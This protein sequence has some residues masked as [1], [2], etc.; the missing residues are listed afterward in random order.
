MNEA[1]KNGTPVPVLEESF[2]RGRGR[3][4]DE[5]ARTRILDAALKLLEERSFPDI[6]ADALAERAGASKATIYRW[7]PNKAAVLIEA[8]REVVAQE[9]P[10]PRT[11]DL[12]DD[13]RQQLRNFVE[14]LTGRRGRIFKGFFAAAQN[15]PEVSAAFETVWRNPRRAIAKSCLEVHRGRQLRDDADLDVVMDT[16][17]GPLYYRLIFGHGELSENY[18]DK[19]SEVVLQGILRN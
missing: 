19:V 11:G 12:G 5:V 3:P 7:W 2:A 18:A 9:L 4:R 17:Y 15:D 14:L 16:M 10:F 6:T 8:F 1:A 13:I